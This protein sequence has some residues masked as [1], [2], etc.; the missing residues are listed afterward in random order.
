MTPNTHFLISNS[1]HALSYLCVCKDILAC[2]IQFLHVQRFNFSDASTNFLCWTSSNH[3]IF[4]IPIVLRTFNGI[5][6]STMSIPQI[7]AE[8]RDYKSSSI[9]WG[10]ES[11]NHDDPQIATCSLSALDKCNTH[12]HLETGTSTT[13]A[14]YGHI[15]NIAH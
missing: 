4:L 7:I 9:L 6:T 2:L 12:V 1:F 15:G 11:G 5:T 3:T 13:L 8:S 14:I 10:D